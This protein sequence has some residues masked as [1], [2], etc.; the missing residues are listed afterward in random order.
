MRATI[1]QNLIKTIK[2]DSRPFEIRDDR[3]KGLLLRVQPSGVMSYYVEY[4]RGKRMCL[5]R[6]DVL[7]PADA[8]EKAK[9]VLKQV[10]DG[11]DPVAAAKL[12]KAHTLEGFID[13][14]YQPWAEANIRTHKTTVRRLKASFAGFMKLRLADIE[15]V[16]VERWRADRLKAGA[17]PSTVN[18]DLDDL[19]S[20]LAKAAEWGFIEASPVAKVAR[21]RVDDR[22]TVRYL[23]DKEKT[24]LLSALEAREERIRSERDS[25][26]RW[27]AE[28]GRNLLP[29]LRAIA[30]ADH[31]KPMV[32]V[33]LHTGLRYGELANLTWG[34]ID[35]SIP[36]LTVHGFKAKSKRTR[37]VPLNDLAS[38][39]LKKWRAQ[40]EETRGLVF[41]NRDGEPFDNV[42]TSWEGVLKKAEII[43][44]RW[45]DLRHT[46]ASQLVM[47]GVDLNTVRELLGHSD[48]QM[49]LRYAHLAPEHKAAA[50]ARLVV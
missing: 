39:T 44:F 11:K 18:R 23:S 26:N 9:G 21:S 30:F 6:A 45:H 25:A 4:A 50:V 3:L 15:P 22:A 47:A 43:K 31:L 13:D 7:D 14:E 19:K 10:Y 33:S 37:H 32:L 20:S 28:R 27:R 42:R 40:A 49:T 41:P 2:P 36:Q 35:F 38:E 8:R 12:G 1:S 46:F 34:D 24:A 17:K 48:Y 16:L 5:G 29:N